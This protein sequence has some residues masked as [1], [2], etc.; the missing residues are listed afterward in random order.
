MYNG[1]EYPLLTEPLAACRK[2]PRTGLRSTALL[3]G[4][5]ATFEIRNAELLLKD[6]QIETPSAPGRWESVLHEFTGGQDELKA[7][8]FT[9]E[10]TVGDGS[11]V[12]YIHIGYASIHENYILMDIRNGNLVKETS[13]T[14]ADYKRLRQEQV[15]AEIRQI[16]K[17]AGRKIVLSITTVFLF[18]LLLALIFKLF[19]ALAPCFPYAAALCAVAAVLLIGFPRRKG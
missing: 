7:D 12:E 9:G 5:V 3:R 17:G 1:R 4:Y 13:M 2:K 19:P 8:W 10:L 15:K 14:G 18:P 16:G 6:I 11:I